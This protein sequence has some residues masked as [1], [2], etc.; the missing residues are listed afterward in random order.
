MLTRDPVTKAIINNEDSYYKT[1]V[2]RRQDKDK[3]KNL[4]TEL[5]EL[6]AELSEIKKLLLQ[7]MSGK[8]N[9]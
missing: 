1:I 7:G 6:R 2:A 3:N 5:A 4:E 9:G 8:N